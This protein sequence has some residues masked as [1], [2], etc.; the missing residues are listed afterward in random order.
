MSNPKH[1]ANKAHT[2]YVTVSGTRGTGKTALAAEIANYLRQRGAITRMND[3]GHA[4][5]PERFGNQPDWEDR[6]IVI[7]VEPGK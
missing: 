6:T 1:D 3:E 4:I 2:L 5:N 7:F